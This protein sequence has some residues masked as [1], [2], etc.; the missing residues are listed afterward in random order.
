[1]SIPDHISES[2]LTIFGLKILKFFDAD[3]DP[4]SATMMV[5]HLKVERVKV[6][7]FLEG[8]YAGECEQHVEG[9]NEGVVGQNHRAQVLLPVH[10]HLYSALNITQS[11]KR[12]NLVGF[13][14]KIGSQHIC[15]RPATED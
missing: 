4:G 14:T 7:D 11:D 3:P 15:S 9:K 8:E 12:Q 10:R 6:V 5:S 2:L 13:A 1:M